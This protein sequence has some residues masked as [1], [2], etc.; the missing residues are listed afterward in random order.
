MRRQLDAEELV[1]AA[2]MIRALGHPVRLRLVQALERGECCVSDLQNALGVP[3]AIVSQQ[4]ARM[5]AA[6]IVTCRR[7]GVNV[8]YVVAEPRVLAMLNCL[9]AGS[10]TAARRSNRFV[11]QS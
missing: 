10:S 5:K 11:R 4:L 7:D 6:G 3:Q 2:D 1:R 8:R 9:R